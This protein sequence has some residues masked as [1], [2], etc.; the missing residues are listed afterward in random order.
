M[1]M[2]TNYWNDTHNPDVLVEKEFFKITLSEQEVYSEPSL[3][4]AKYLFFHLPSIIIVKGYA[5]G[6]MNSSVKSMIQQFINEHKIELQ[7]KVEIK[8]KY[9]M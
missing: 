6:F 3:E 2:R 9:R 1:A 4:D 7:N 5:L 8:M